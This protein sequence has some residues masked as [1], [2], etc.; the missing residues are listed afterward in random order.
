MKNFKICESRIFTNGEQ[1]YR[2]LSEKL[3]IVKGAGNAEPSE[4]ELFACLEE[5][6]GEVLLHTRDLPD[7]VSVTCVSSSPRVKAVEFLDYLFHSYGV[8]KG[9]AGYAQGKI[10]SVLLSVEM[11]DYDLDSPEAFFM[12]RGEGYFA[13]CESVDAGTY[14]QDHPEN[15]SRMKQYIKKPIS[16]AYVKSLD[17]APE[18]TLLCIKSLENET[19]VRFRAEKDSY[20]MIGCLG[21]VYQ[22]KKEKFESTYEDGGTKLD[23][24]QTFF[25]FIPAVELPEKGEQFPI[26]EMAN[27][28]FP[29]PGSGIYA[30]M[31][32]RRTRVYDRE[33]SDYFVGNPGDYMAIRSDDRTD[34]YIIQQEV[35][36][37][38]YEEKNE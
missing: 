35:F 4:K 32:T 7:G 38:T 18:G 13:E 29:K 19:G 28:C 10:P 5:A 3:V 11:E 17:I 8:M 21:E 12:M 36:H 30:E 24:F 6:E 2:H 22:I 34:I 37:R 15:I 26:D 16:W 31:L 14:A 1:V 23:I 25:D 20:V 33:G 9:D 27:L